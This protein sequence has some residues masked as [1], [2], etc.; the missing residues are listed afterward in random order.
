M[1]QVWVKG[2][3]KDYYEAETDFNAIIKRGLLD[4]VRKK[5][6]TAGAKIGEVEAAL[7]EHHDENGTNGQ[8]P[9]GSNETNG[10]LSREEM[11]VILDRFRRAKELHQKLDGLIQSPLIDHLL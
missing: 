3:R 10:T 11:D 9:A 6:T 1:R 4:L 5:L 8:H 2:D 7:S